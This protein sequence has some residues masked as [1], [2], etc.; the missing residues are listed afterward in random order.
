M[1][2]I[3]T[4]HFG[5]HFEN[6]CEYLSLSMLNVISVAE[7]H[8]QSGFHISSRWSLV[9]VTHFYATLLAALM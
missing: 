2:V 6:A 3:S 9:T 1:K 8:V 4:V 7:W 5:D